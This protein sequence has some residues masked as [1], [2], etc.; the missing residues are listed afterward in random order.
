MILPINNI[1]NNI[2]FSANGKENDNNLEYTHDTI[3]KNNI[4]TRTRIGID[5]FSNA[6]TLY[7]AKG[8]KGNKN[9]NFYEFLTMGMVPYLT[10]SAMLMAVFNSANKHFAPFA[11][12]KAG[13]LGKKMALGV[14]FYGLAKQASK[15]LINTPVK[16]MTGVDPELP[17]AKVNYELPDDINDTDITSIEYHKVFESV[18]FP[19][20]DLLYGDEARGQKR[21]Y[22]YDKVA[23][24]LGMGNNLKDSDQE[25]K[26]RIK[27]IIVKSNVAKNISSYLW[28]ALG[29]GLAFQKPWENFFNVATLKF[30]KGKEFKT[31]T[32]SFFRNLGKSAEHLYTGEGQKFKH[33]GKILLYTALTSSILG[34][35]NVMSSS[36]K[37]SKLDASDIIKKDEKYVIN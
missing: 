17:Y 4:V 3:L 29:V 11:R 33:G 35:V 18:E 14:I 31:S 9:A 30:W 21:N 24:K 34:V 32:K 12:S 10:G 6:I 37:P 23:K 13:P 22:Y 20:W 5:K 8:L 26:P 27:E 16:I 2:P 36:Q 1:K 28:A 19:R 15:T 7:P 25:V